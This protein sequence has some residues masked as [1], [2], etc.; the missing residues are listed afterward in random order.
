MNCKRQLQKPNVKTQVEKNSL[1][2][3]YK[4]L[5]NSQRCEFSYDFGQSIKEWAK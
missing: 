2:G 3:Y 5:K 1:A 4:L